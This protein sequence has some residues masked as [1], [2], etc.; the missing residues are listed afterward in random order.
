MTNSSEENLIRW[1]DL[2]AGGLDKLI[3]TPRD[4]VRYVNGL[5]VTGGIVSDEVNPVDLAAI[6]AIRTFAPEF[7]SFIRDNRDIMVGPTGGSLTIGDPTTREQHRIRLDEAYSLCKPELQT[8]I[9][10]ICVQLFPE[11]KVDPVFRTGS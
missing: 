11:T 7:Y 6:E 9:R 2:K 10:E 8:A 4:V 5:V 3:S 1:V